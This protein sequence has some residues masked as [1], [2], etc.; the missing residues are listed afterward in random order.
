M[1]AFS[2]LQIALALCLVLVGSAG[3]TPTVSSSFVVTEVYG[4]G[5]NAGA[6]YNADFVELRNVGSS[7]ASLNGYSLQYASNTGSSWSKTDLPNVSLAPGQY[8]LVQMTAAGAN[9]SA[10][11]TPDHTASPVISMAA[12][13]GKVALV[14]NTTVL[15]GACPTG[16]TIVDFVGYGSTASCFEGAGPA[17]APSN[18]TSAQRVSGT[19]ADQNATDFATGPPSPQNTQSPTAV[20]LR[21]FTATRVGTRVVLRWRTASELGVLGFRVF[22][23][24]ER[25]NGRLIAAGG[26]TAGRAYT[27]RTGARP[28]ST[29]R[30]E[31]VSASGTR[32]AVAVTR[33]R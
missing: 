31:A 21:F 32:L 10:L 26:G 20:A 2:S 5:G 29:F 19:D 15:T 30:L 7:A 18:T 27:W 13:A 1:R 28:S 11:P 4:G 14:S 16:A 22:S 23:G 8:F 9:G 6:P 3:S 25:L 17:P 12:T 24:R 33:S